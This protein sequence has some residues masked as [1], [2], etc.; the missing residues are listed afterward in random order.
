MKN[1]TLREIAATCNGTYYGC[2][3]NLDKEVSDV[4]I[5]S[6]KISKDCL[7]VAIKGARV[8]GHDFIPQ[9]IEGGAL[10]ALSEKVI[11]GAN[12]SYIVVKSCTQALKDLAAHYRT[13]LGIKVVG[14]SGSVGKTST[15]E[16][17]A[18]V[19]GKKYNV[20]KTEG[21]FNNEIGLPLTIFRIREEHEVAV[22][23]M[24][25]SHFGDMEPL[26]SIA[27]PDICVITNIGYAHLENL[28]TRDGIL[29]EKTDMF[30]F[31]NEGGTIILNGND[32]KLSTVEDY[33][34]TKPVF[35]GT[36]CNRAYSACDI[37]DMGLEGTEALFKTPDS[38]FKAHI[39]VPGAH[40]ILNALAGIAVGRTLGM[41]DAD[42]KKGIEALL[43]IAGRNNIIKTEKY[44]I[45]D[46]CYNAN[47]ASMKA[48]LD[49]LKKAKTRK[50]AILGDMF[51]LGEDEKAMHA[52]IGAYAATLPV[53]I[54]VCIG[55]LS[56]NMEDGARRICSET[57]IYWY[58]IKEAFIDDID[59]ILEDG[60][61]I[62][63]KASH[64]MEF[65]EIIKKLK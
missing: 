19:L 10:C 56:R 28:K 54:L 25:I 50:V 23:E 51:E 21:N 35:F 12:Y 37:N 46:D 4:V 17:I 49:V 55:D 58:K 57:K 33:K 24:G 29:K 40:M 6:R 7:F 26:A 16:M 48:S 14:I 41:E 65:P 39:F 27:K 3:C 60:D 59:T 53:D 11:E 34:G 20:L 32:D 36:E 47:P 43:P 42:I 15:K 30:R 64:G 5:D 63:V 1:M 18:S 44:T 45:I 2:D 61:T 8:D 13:A 38:E 9:V 31:M 22:L 52:E 62:L